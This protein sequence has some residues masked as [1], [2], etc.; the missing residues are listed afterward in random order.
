MV[1]SQAR[2]AINEL[3]HAARRRLWRLDAEEALATMADGA[4]L[5]DMSV[6]PGRIADPCPGLDR[7]EQPCAQSSSP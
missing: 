5:I 1:D 7:G 2:T 4:L 3:L 6:V